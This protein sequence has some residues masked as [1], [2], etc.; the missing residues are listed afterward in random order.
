MKKLVIA[1]N[2]KMNKTRNEAIDFVTE[3][4]AKELNFDGE[5]MIFAP[6]YILSELNNLANDN[7]VIGAQNVHQMASGAYTGETSIEMIKSIGINTTLIG[8]SER[9]QY[10]NET[11]KIVNEKTIAAL[12]SGLRAIVCVGETKDEREAGITNEILNTQTVKAF[13][14]VSAEDMKNVIVAYEPVWAIGTGLVASNED[15]NEACKYIRGVVAGLYS[16]EVA[17]A[18]VI[19]YGGSVNPANVKELMAQSDIDGALVGGASLEVDSFVS[20]LV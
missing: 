12:N 10:F 2:W 13:E 15:A 8:H 9:R 18:L 1:G 17:D 20:L 14:N 16:Q 3:L 4:N 11:D 6:T 19:Q 5:M 7:L